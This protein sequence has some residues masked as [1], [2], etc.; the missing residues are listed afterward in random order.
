MMPSC[1]AGSNAGDEAIFPRKTNV[2]RSVLRCTITRTP[3]ESVN[4]TGASTLCAVVGVLSDLEIQLGMTMGP[5]GIRF[6]K[7]SLAAASLFCELPR[8]GVSLGLRCPTTVGRL[9]Y[10]RAAA[11]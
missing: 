1:P 4:S 9:K 3:L 6:E 7:S 11:T 8:G 5:L 10:V 2:G